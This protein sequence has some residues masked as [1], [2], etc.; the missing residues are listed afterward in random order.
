MFH[1]IAKKKD[2]DKSFRICFGNIYMKAM[3]SWKAHVDLQKLLKWGFKTYQVGRNH[4]KASLR[5]RAP[6]VII[7]IC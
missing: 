5:A 4:L 3:Q 6:H 2:L 1:S 7:F